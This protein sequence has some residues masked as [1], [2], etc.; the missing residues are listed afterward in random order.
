MVFL[1]VIPSF[2]TEHQHEIG[3]GVFRKVKAP[4]SLLSGDGLNS[5]LL[6]WALVAESGQSA[7]SERV[8]NPGVDIDAVAVLG[9][10]L[11]IFCTSELTAVLGMG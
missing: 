6:A 4:K 3:G 9:R 5:R 8:E 2:P 1:G 10:T 7:D 11:G